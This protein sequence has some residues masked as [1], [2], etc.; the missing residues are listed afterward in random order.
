M[1]KAVINVALISAVSVLTIIGIY[2]FSVAYQ[3][4]SVLKGLQERNIVESVNQIEFIKMAKEQAGI[5]STYQSAY[6]ISK[7][8]TYKH[9]TYGISGTCDPSLLTGLPDDIPYWRV[10]DNA[11]FDSLASPPEMEDIIKTQLKQEIPY[12][13]KEYM[14][15]IKTR[16]DIILPEYTTDATI[17]NDE[18][19]SF[20]LSFTPQEIKFDS[21]NL[22]LSKFLGTIQKTIEIPIRRMIKFAAVSIVSFDPIPAE[23]ESANQ[24]MN[25]FP[26]SPSTVNPDWGDSKL[27][28]GELSG[29][30]QTTAFQ[31][32]VHPDD[33]PYTYP[34]KPQLIPKVYCNGKFVSSVVDKVSS[35]SEND[36]LTG[37]SV[38][39]YPDW[40]SETVNSE[41]ET[42]C[43][44]PSPEISSASC[45]CVK[46]I[47]PASRQVKVGDGTEIVPLGQ[48]PVV[49]IDA[50]SPP[51]ACTTCFATEGSD[52][53]QYSFQ[54]CPNGFEETGGVGFLSKEKSMA[55]FSSISL[56]PILP[57]PV[58]P[59]CVQYAD[60]VC[61][62]SYPIEL[63]GQCINTAEKE[64][65]DPSIDTRIGG[66]CYDTLCLDDPLIE[67][68]E[69]CFVYPADCP[70]GF[71]QEYDTDNC[72][73]DPPVSKTCPDGF[74]F[75]KNGQCAQ[76]ASKICPSGTEEFGS[77]GR[78]YNTPPVES[79]PVCDLRKNLHEKTCNYN[80]QADAAALV[81]V[82]DKKNKY[83]V[84][85]SA[86]DKTDFRNLEL[87]FYVLSKN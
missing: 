50:L 65:A 10:F 63:N 74:P 44:T 5:Y 37:L 33:E 75:S 66:S 85:D 42:T 72:R 21:E 12:R 43:L 7:Y 73:T 3:S 71:P 1:M 83:P 64:C 55:S 2:S 41:D 27:N 28:N 84:Y 31:S 19:I 35:V 20:T 87:Q 81:N 77:T 24:N 49:G 6:D 25:A 36:P 13:F 62:D 16:Y 80:Y 76:Y 57:P 56:V 60:K 26:I 4:H 68:P 45:D 29:S 47:C 8:G 38:R 59:E 32:C 67:N 40:V 39:T 30:C 58:I 54:A 70:D 69:E 61:P 34:E 52:C 15:A 17:L 48:G 9:G 23:I 86:E 79:G 22:D 14:D 18:E 51:V 78:C 53:I 82:K 11:C 46:W